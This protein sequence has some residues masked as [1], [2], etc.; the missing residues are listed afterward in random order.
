[1]STA[2][3][4]T[5]AGTVFASMS[6]MLEGI[7]ASVDANEAERARLLT[8]QIEALVENLTPL[9]EEAMSLIVSASMRKAKATV[10][11]EESGLLDDDGAHPDAH[12]GLSHVID[13]LSGQWP[14][15]NAMAKLAQMFDPDNDMTIAAEQGLTVSEYHRAW[16]ERREAELA[17]DAEVDA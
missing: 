8:K 6:K 3:Q 9:A 14:L 16:M 1:M 12:D 11:V 4:E 15:F 13:S 2:T 10:A 5:T 7:A 17:A